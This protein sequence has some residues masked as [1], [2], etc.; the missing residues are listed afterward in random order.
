MMNEIDNY[1][2]MSEITLS[3]LGDMDQYEEPENNEL[4]ECVKIPIISRMILPTTCETCNKLGHTAQYC[5]QILFIDN[6][7]NPYLS[8]FPTL[9]S[10]YKKTM[11]QNNQSQTFSTIY[12]K[13]TQIH[14]YIKSATHYLD[15]SQN[16]NMDKKTRQECLEQSIYYSK[17]AES[18]VNKYY[19]ECFHN[20]EVI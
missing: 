14:T 4:K 1:S 16:K 3:D 11:L 20:F 17:L 8:V 9:S 5:K 12:A 15:L 10:N 18:Y 2:T 13:N 7:K 19:L 6:N